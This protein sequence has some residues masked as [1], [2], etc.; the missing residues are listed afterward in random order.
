[1]TSTSS[2][3]SR[4]NV[5]RIKAG[6]KPLKHATSAAKMQADIEKLKP[7]RTSDVAEYAR[8]KGINPKVARAL[9]RRHFAKPATGWVMTD[10]IKAK[11]DECAERVAA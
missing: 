2:L 9:L 10:E 7:A 6:M 1:M 11:L 3:L 4:L 8:E 5:L